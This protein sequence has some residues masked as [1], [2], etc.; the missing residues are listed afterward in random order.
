M[1]QDSVYE[2]VIEGHLTVGLSGGGKSLGNY[3]GIQV[4]IQ[5]T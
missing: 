3:F 2:Y 5:W 4:N 1:L